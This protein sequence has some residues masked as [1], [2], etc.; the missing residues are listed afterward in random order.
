MHVTADNLT[1]RL[2]VLVSRHGPPRRYLVAWSGGRDSSVMLHAVL[3]SSRTRKTPLCAVH[4]NHQLQAAADDWQAHCER[5]AKAMGVSFQ[6][7][8]APVPDNPPGGTEAAARQLRYDALSRLLEP[9]DWLLSAHHRN[10]QAET[11]LL[12]VMRGS[13][14]AGLAGIGEFQ[15]L[16][17]GHL[18][19][20]MRDVP[21][22]MIAAYAAQHELRWVQDPSNDDTAFDRNFV[23]HEVLPLL[24]S[25]WPAAVTSLARS[26]VFAGEAETLLA[27]LAAIDLVQAGDP[28][29]MDTGV[30]MSLSE[31]RQRNLLR[32]AMRELGLPLPPARKLERIVTELL[33][34]RADAKPLVQ[35]QGGEARRY[36]SGLYLGIPLPAVPDAPDDRLVAGTSL[37]LGDGLGELQLVPGVGGIA[38]ALA[39]SGLAVRFRTGG[40][41]LR[42]AGRDHTHELKKLLQE[43]AIVPWMRSRLPLFYAGDDLVAVADLW[44]AEAHYDPAGHAIQWNGKPALH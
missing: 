19:R 14:I 30:L 27:E 42:P 41:M 29:C 13:G 34:A 20:P 43:A 7:L 37:A 23:R 26:T 3:T 24:E 16:A 17:A 38:P 33:P 31:P 11:L 18:V 36:R 12:N 9:G 25:R 1:E 6:A 22:A 10:D 40:E 4:V 28:D 15:P 32:H 5:E 21:A 44:I 8:L 35:W 39:A 2:E